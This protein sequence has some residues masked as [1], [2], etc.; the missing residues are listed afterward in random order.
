MQ[1]SQPLPVRELCF[2]STVTLLCCCC[3]KQAI[4]SRL[5]SSLSLQFPHNEHCVYKIAQGTA[6]MLLMGTAGKT[7][8]HP[9]EDSI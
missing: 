4:S 3:G 1:I 9:T 7:Q 8:Q 2:T 5:G 6:L